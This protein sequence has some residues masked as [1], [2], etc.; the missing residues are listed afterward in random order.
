MFMLE[1]ALEII[2]SKLPISMGKERSQKPKGWS[3]ITSLGS[4]SG[5]N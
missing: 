2:Y 3:G 4:V 1:E 5:Q